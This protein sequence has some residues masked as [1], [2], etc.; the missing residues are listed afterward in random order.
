MTTQMMDRIR[1][2]GET[3]PLGFRGSPSP[4]P[5]GGLPDIEVDF[6]SPHTA[7]GRGYLATWARWGD[8]LLLADLQGF[9]RVSRGGARLNAPE[10]RPRPAWLHELEWGEFGLPEVF[11]SPGPVFARWVTTELRVPVCRVTFS[12][13]SWR[14]L[15]ARWLVLTVERGI[16]AAERV[17]RGET[18]Y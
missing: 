17:E 12:H 14:T 5:P 10:D 2:A 8:R 11:G 6:N 7:L 9:G 13:N 16:V 4:I 1:I 15:C 18:G 3:Y